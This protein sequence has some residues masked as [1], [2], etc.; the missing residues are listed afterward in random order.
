MLAV[1]NKRRDVAA[2]LLSAGA[3]PDL[4]EEVRG[5]VGVCYREVVC[6]AAYTKD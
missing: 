1:Q 3:N 6:S 2:L 5:A 4:Q